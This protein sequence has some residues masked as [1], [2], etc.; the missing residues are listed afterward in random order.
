M[1]HKSYLTLLGGA[2]LMA[3]APAHAQEDF[4]ASCG[5]VMEMT[6]GE[7]LAL[8]QSDY[9]AK[10]DELP[11]H[12]DVRGTIGGNVKFALLLPE[13]WNSRFVMVGNGGKA[14]SLQLNDASQRMSEGF[15]AITTDTGHDASIPEQAGSR[16]GTDPD[17]ERDFGY[18]AVHDTA[19]TG[20]ELTEVL[21]G[22]EPEQSYWIGCSTG[23]RQGM[24]EFQRFPDDFDGYVVGAPVYN[25][26]SQQMS[27]PAFLRPL[28]PDNNPTGGNPIIP[29]E[30]LSV[31]GAAVTAH[32]D[33]ADGLV[34]G[35][36]SNPAACDFS[37]S[38]DLAI[39]ESGGDDCF[40]TA[41]VEALEKVYAGIKASDGSSLVNGMPVGG[42][43]VPG[44]WGSWLIP[45]PAP[46]VASMPLLHRVMLDAFNYLMFEEDSADY[47][48]MTDFDFETDPAR[49][50]GAA[51][52]YN[53]TDPNI[54]DVKSSGKKIIMYH[55]W[56]DAA[57]NPY[58]SIDYRTA[59]DETVGEADSFLKLY[60][61][62]GMAHCRGG[63]GFEN[64]DFVT[65]LIDWVENDKAPA[66]IEATRTADMA[67]RALC[68]YPQLAMY[69]GKGD[70]NS[71]DSYSCQ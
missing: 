65:A 30:K 70:I 53:A 66:A 67:T 59:V 71:S 6:L 1:Q 63:I 20:K 62:P 46:D 38:R 47:N 48:Y 22:Q 8:T 41:Q 37:P 44:S 3:A 19:S 56:A 10:T 9:V 7:G 60:M 29:F 40:T 26:T 45:K 69:D 51:K 15:A 58:N 12:C 18:Q 24:M 23:G 31:L 68:P 16:F 43:A 27:A 25:Y 42:E 55:G 13:D 4:A 28:Y 39:C 35:L 17:M 11:A 5:Q 32:C 34:D 33:G 49:M 64:A 36:V 54:A 61:V 52:T 14:G 50:A 2:L 57:S 21:Y